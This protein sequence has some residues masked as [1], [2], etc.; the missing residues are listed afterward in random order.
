MKQKGSLTSWDDNKGFGFI[1]PD[2]DGERVFAHISAF[3]GRGR[4]SASRKV[5][6]EQ[7][8]DAQGRLQAAQFQYSGVSRLG[9]A[10]VPG[11]WIALL[12]AT[13]VLASLS[14]LF[15]L[16]YVP[17]FLPAT[18]GV[19]SL[20]TFLMYAVDKRAAERVSW[21]VPEGR[22]HFFELLCGWPGALVGQQFFRHKTRKL[23]FQATFWFYVL[24]NLT[25]LGW[26]LAWPDADFARQQLGINAVML[27]RI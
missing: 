9:A 24:L 10:L 11:V 12:I 23:S 3:Q 16:G 20:I 26:L 1:T 22:L 18:Y 14:L 25:V 5:V 2:E 17:L 27:I 6:Y 4:P 7:S 13:A 21:R 8:K 19:M 15:K